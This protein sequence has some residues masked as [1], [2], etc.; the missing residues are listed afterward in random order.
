MG[1]R[2]E[3]R[4]IDLFA[5]MGGIRLGFEQAARALGF[6]P[7]CV[8]TSE[9]KKSAI[10]VLRSNYPSDL[11]SGDITQIPSQMIPCF[12]VLLGGF[13]CQAFSSAGKRSGFADTR[14]TLFFEIERILCDK[15]PQAFL[16]ENVEGLVNHDREDNKTPIGRTLATIL[17][18]LQGLGYTVSWS[19]LNAVDYGVPQERRRIYIVGHRG[20]TT[21][22]FPAPSSQRPTLRNV[23]EQGRPLED[24]AFVRSLLKHFRP[25]QL[26]GKSIKDKRGGEGNIHSWEIGA[27][28]EVSKK[29]ALLLGRL[30]KERRKKKWAEEYGIDWMDGM[31]LSLAQIQSFYPDPELEVMLARLVDLGYLKREYPKRRYARLEG[32]GTV[33]YREQDP[34]LPLGYNIVTGK[35]SFPISKILDPE[36]IAPT[37][38]AT[39]M[40]KLYVVDG[41]GLRPLSL[42]EGLRLC[43][44]PDDYAF[45]VKDSEGYDLLGNTVVV[46][47]IKAVAQALLRQAIVDTEA[48]QAE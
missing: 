12:D 25:K 18:S 46:P 10:K 4:Y 8:F 38:V 14:G 24:T 43:G 36:G 2:G 42:K 37:L 40:S 33:Y 19:V 31:S 34:S 39:D 44:Y 48:K 27:K 15:Q 3:L 13:P 41:E 29:E 28:G 26:L 17:N 7:K 5:G 16:L 11:I 20:D 1:E 45:D 23:L 47:V 35:L 32:R 21:L 9:I 30:L 6:S 22:V